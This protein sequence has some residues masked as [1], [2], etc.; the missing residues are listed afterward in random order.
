MP[1]PPGEKVR[2]SHMLIKHAGSRN[3]VSRRTNQS[4]KHITVEAAEAE[5]KTCIEALYNPADTRDMATKFAALAA[6]RSDCGSFA[7]GGDLGHF[8]HKEMQSQFEEATV[9][10]K[11]GEVSPL[12]ESDSGCHIVFRTE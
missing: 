8:G 6:A 9:N 1:I 7:S 5:M 4:T 3:P 2:C 10:T 12:F 11:I